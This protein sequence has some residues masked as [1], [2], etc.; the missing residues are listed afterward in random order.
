M[1][2]CLNS[3]DT[4][5]LIR[6]KLL[7]A[8]PVPTSVERKICICNRNE[9]GGRKGSPINGNRAETFNYLWGDPSNPEI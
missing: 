6:I 3:E 9:C 2:N 4:Y 5:E 7:L 1:Y 8:F